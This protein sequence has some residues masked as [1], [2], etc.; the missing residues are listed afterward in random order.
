MKIDFE[1]PAGAGAEAVG[2]GLD[3]WNRKRTARPEPKTFA[4]VIRD[5]ETVRGG[6]SATLHRDLLFVNDL[7]VDDG[8][9]GSGRGRELMALAEAEARARGA[10]KIVLETNNF[11]AP[12]FY[13][14]LGFAVIGTYTYHADSFRYFLMLKEL[15]PA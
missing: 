13:K 9:R 11:Q 14:H 3:A 12:E 6:L 8:L 10:V 1:E 5:G 7:W 2:A 15:A 4:W